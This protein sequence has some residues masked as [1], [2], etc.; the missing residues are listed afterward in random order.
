VS[1][2]GAQV[3]EVTKPGGDARSGADGARA[4]PEEDLGLFAATGAPAQ[5]AINAVI[6]ISPPNV[7]SRSAVA[8]GRTF[9]IRRSRSAKAIT[10]SPCVHV[11]TTTPWPALMLRELADVS[12]N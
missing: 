9:P 11:A 2:V 12:A 7:A 6:A 4:S 5:A 3:G 8:L 10:Q 1:S